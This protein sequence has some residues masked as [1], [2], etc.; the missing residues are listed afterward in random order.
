MATA[1]SLHNQALI[2]I[3]ALDEQHFFQRVKLF[4]VY[5]EEQNVYGV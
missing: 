2:Q 4:M 3:S 5:E 1:T